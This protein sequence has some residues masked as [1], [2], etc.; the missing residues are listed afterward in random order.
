MS[1]TV[2]ILF[3]LFYHQPFLSGGY[4]TTWN[5]VMVLLQRRNGEVFCFIPP[6]I[7]TNQL[8]LVKHATGT[9]AAWR[10]Q[11]ANVTKTYI[12]LHRLDGAIDRVVNCIFSFDTE[13]ILFAA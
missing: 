7:L 13:R 4:S 10:S 5:Q 2:S 9:T 11:L 6:F 8:T 12:M 3:Y 1:L